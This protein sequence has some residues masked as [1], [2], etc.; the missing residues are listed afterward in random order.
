MKLKPHGKVK[1]HSFLKAVLYSY[2][3]P[4]IPNC[5]L[6]WVFFF[7]LNICVIRYK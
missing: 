5:V 1:M 7:K 4:Y 6:V 3:L 2:K